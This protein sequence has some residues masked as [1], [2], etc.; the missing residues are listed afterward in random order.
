[1]ISQNVMHRPVRTLVTMIA[2]A[3]EVTL[4]II[5]VGVTSAMLLDSA[6]RTEGV[7]ADVMVQAPAA[8]V[9]LGFTGAPIPIAIGTKLTHLDYVQAVAPVLTQLNSTNSLDMVWGIDPASFRGVSGG[10]IVYSGH[11]LHDTD[12]ILVDDVYAQAKKVRVGQ[13]LSMLGHNF[14][15]AGI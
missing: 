13:M 3:L 6:K 5:V 15:V 4:V 10:F 14:H 1:M 11:D 12:D 9:F 7:G 8:S 2:V